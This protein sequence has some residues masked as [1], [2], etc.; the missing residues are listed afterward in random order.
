M[1]G[2]GHQP[3]HDAVGFNLE[4]ADGDVAVHAS[5]QFLQAWVQPFPLPLADS[6][7][8]A[9]DIGGSVAP[10][11]VEA[12]EGPLSAIRLADERLLALPGR[13]TASL[14]EFGIA[15]PGNNSGSLVV[16]GDLLVGPA[17]A[18]RLTT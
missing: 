14:S 8:G 13:R 16:S 12:V 6:A 1:V 9:P 11:V 18:V 15:S 4:W 2:F 10:L 5:R 17:G 3:E 7:A